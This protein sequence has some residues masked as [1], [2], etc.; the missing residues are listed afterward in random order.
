ML[1]YFFCI[2]SL[3]IHG[4]KNTHTSNATLNLKRTFSGASR[5]SCWRDAKP[6]GGCRPPTRVLLGENV[7]KKRK[8]WILL[9]VGG[10][11]WCAPAA[12]PGSANDFVAFNTEKGARLMLSFISGILLF[13]EFQVSGCLADTGFH[14]NNIG[15]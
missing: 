2:M 15:G 8:N 12:P 5:I 14:K 1:Y 10:G 4:F 9:C 7:C 13:C 6:L 11:G 3:V